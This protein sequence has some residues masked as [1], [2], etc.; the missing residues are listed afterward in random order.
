MCI[1][2]ADFWLARVAAQLRERRAYTG[3]LKLR[4]G[5][6]MGLSTESIAVPA[7]F[8]LGNI[9]CVDSAYVHQSHEP[10]QQM[11][12]NIIN[13]S[14]ERDD[15]GTNEPVNGWRAIIDP[16]S[17]ERYHKTIYACVI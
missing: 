4:K 16:Y 15:G 17:I 3:S 10:F 12:K 14:T 5:R 7:K 2:D 8:I 13:W 1:I 6:P 11:V 9:D